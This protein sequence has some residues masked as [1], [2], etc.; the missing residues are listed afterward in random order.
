MSYDENYKQ[1][2]KF[3]LFALCFIA[4]WATY[5]LILS[6]NGNKLG[7]T[8]SSLVMSLIIFFIHKD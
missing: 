2:S 6:V 3:Q 5:F 1:I 4:F 7:A 8:L